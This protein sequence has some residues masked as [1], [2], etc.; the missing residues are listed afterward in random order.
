MDNE[1]ER[2]TGNFFARLLIS[3]YEGAK[4]GARVVS[5]LTE[6]F[7]VN[8]GMPQGS[9]LLPFFCSGDRCCYKICQ[10]VR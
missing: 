8:V 5:E 1:E 6:Q 2:N 4:T 3:L 10:R 9:V 7:E